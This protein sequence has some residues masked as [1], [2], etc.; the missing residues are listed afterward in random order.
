LPEWWAGNLVVPR[1]RGLSMARRR[2][3]Q[4]VLGSIPTDPKITQVRIAP[5]P[6]PC[7]LAPATYSFFRLKCSI[8][9]PLRCLI[10]GSRPLS[11]CRTMP[12]RSRFGA[13]LGPGP[14]ERV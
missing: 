5:R 7:S 14:F 9:V 1:P 8:R 12:L 4:T 11:E 10:N 2:K 3:I 13:D 6:V